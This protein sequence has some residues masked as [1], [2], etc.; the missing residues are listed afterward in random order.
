MSICPSPNGAPYGGDKDRE[1]VSFLSFEIF[2]YYIERNVVLA[3]HDLLESN[4]N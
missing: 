2:K 4:A 1:S 3:L